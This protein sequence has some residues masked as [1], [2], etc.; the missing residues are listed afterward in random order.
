MQP[1]GYRAQEHPGLRA[2]RF[3]QDHMD[4]GT[5]SRESR[6]MNGSSPLRML[7]N[8]R[9]IVT[10][11][12]VRLFYSKDDQGMSRVTPKQLLDA[13]LRMKRTGYCWQNC[14]PRRHSTTCVTSTP[15]I[16]A[17]SPAST[18]RVQRSPSNSLCCW[19]SRAL[20]DG[21]CHVRTSGRCSTWSST[22]VIQ[23]ACRR[24]HRFIDEIWYQPELKRA[25]QPAAV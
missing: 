21:S 16:Q 5:D 17:L 24:Q 13:C 2:H 1:R 4:Q 20:P 19:S 12:H 15:V 14:D 22:V 7:Q 11:N 18:P 23:F 6:V 9:S 10:S 8:W 3:G 25:G